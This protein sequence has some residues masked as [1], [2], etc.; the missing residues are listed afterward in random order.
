MIELKRQ[1]NDL[2]R[3]LGRPAPYASDLVAG[4]DAPVADAGAAPAKANRGSSV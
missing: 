2:A 1:V 4:G 3:E